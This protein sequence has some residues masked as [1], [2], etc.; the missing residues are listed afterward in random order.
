MPNPLRALPQGDEL[1]TSFM[2][3]W[4]DDV[5]GNVSKLINAHKN[6]YVAHGNLPGKLLQQEFHVWF[7]ST[8]QYAGTTEQFKAVAEMVA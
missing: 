3:V 4:A 1:F 6:V 8:S 5:G 2:I 7:G